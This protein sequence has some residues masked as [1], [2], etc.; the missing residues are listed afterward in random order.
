M[1]D[2]FIKAWLRTDTYIDNLSPGQRRKLRALCE[3]FFEAGRTYS[4]EKKNEHVEPQTKRPERQNHRR[5]EGD[6]P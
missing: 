3:R 4:K 6:A 2:P 1:T 5:R